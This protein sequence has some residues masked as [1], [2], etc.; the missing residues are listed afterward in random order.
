MK[1]YE[2]HIKY[3]ESKKCYGMMDY[4]GNWIKEELEDGDRIDIVINGEVFSTNFDNEFNYPSLRPHQWSNW[5][6]LTKAHAAYYDFEREDK[7]PLTKKEERLHRF[8]STF[9]LIGIAILISLLLGA[10]FALIGMGEKSFTDAFV[11]CFNYVFWGFCA[12]LVAGAI[13]LLLG[14]LPENFCIGFGCAL[15]YGTILLSGFLSNFIYGEEIN[16][17]FISFVIVA[18]VCYIAWLTQFKD[19]K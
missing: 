12:G 19:N 6:A 1:M 10:F 15:Y 13:L 11:V 17:L 4:E 3:N 9:L 18:L 16:R 2:G 8:L 7:K 5:E 14:I